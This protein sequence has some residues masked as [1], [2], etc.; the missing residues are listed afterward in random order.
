MS[1]WKN[2]QFS[3]QTERGWKTPQVNEASEDT[4]NAVMGIAVVI[5]GVLGFVVAVSI[6]ALAFMAVATILDTGISYRDCVLLSSV[7]IL[8]R[9][10]DSVVFRKLRNKE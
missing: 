3:D 9:G 2:P 6:N 5:S 4:R 8:W 10:Y 7:Y 1:E